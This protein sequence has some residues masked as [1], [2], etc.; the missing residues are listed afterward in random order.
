MLPCRVGLTSNL[1]CNDF[2]F[3]INNECIDSNLLLVF[4]I[5]LSFDHVEES[6]FTSS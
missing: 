4:D 2:D 3:V 6:G 5:D 1:E